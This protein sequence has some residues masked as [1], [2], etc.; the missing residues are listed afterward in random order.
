M[1]TDEYLNAI[2]SS[3]VGFE[4][5][6][7]S[8]SDIPK[9]KESLTHTLNKRI[10][11]EDKAHSDFTPSESVYKLEPDTSGGSGM[12]ELVT[13]PMKY[14]EAK[15][16]LAKTLKWIKENGSTNDHCSIHINL[17]FNLEVLG[18]GFDM[19]LLDVGKF[20]LSF[21]EDEV[22]K[23]FPNR[24]DSV[25]AK[26]I[27]FVM[28][29]NGM[30]HNSP[31]KV[32]WKNYQFVNSKYYGVNFTKIPKG[33]IEFR[34]VGG[35][36][37]ENEYQ[38]ILKMMNHFISSLY[39]TLED[40]TYTEEEVKELDKLLKLHGNVIKAFRSY[41]DFV[42]LYPK[43]KISVDLKTAKE[44]IKMYYPNIRQRLF[45]LLT[46]A[47]MKEGYVNYDSDQGKI[48]VK[49]AKLDR[50]FLIKGID[51]VDCDVRGNIE[52]CD[53]FSCNIKDSSVIDSN[54]FNATLVA[55]SK[56]ESCY[57]SRNVIL[58]ECYVYGINTV[59]SGKMKGG[60]F[61]KGR[62]TKHAGFK[63]TEVIEY[64]KIK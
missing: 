37:Y 39:Y 21:D 15:L 9:T 23:M 58:T 8:K 26:S 53:I 4:F 41:D 44:I 36:D 50:C 17:A 40:P 27:K 1:Q 62:I 45:D 51:L 60:I 10:H 24:K 30:I 3:K 11:I 2:H 57:V 14:P 46:K 29:L 18:A 49:D 31:D 64:E 5:E 48:Q 52:N 13:G 34:Y 42:I 61:R 20:V 6:F 19:K 59:F 38:K 55:D 54:L 12:I 22:Y 33:Y 25:Y 7:F 47:G 56:I 43:I 35:K 63:D 16:I 28:P 32:N